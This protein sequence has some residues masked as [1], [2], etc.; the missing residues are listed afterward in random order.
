MTA[1]HLLTTVLHEDAQHGPD[2]DAVLRSVQLGVQRHRRRRRT[3]AI[4]TVAV[5]TAAAVAVPS[6]LP[7]EARTDQRTATAP[8]A[9]P[10]SVSRPVTPPVTVTPSTPSAR[11]AGTVVLVPAEPAPSSFAQALGTVPQGWEPYDDPTTNRTHATLYASPD[12]PVQD[13]RQTILVD[14]T[15]PQWAPG[16]LTG[17]IDG[18]PA[19]VARGEDGSWQALVDIGGGL[20]LT[21]AFPTALD[22]LTADQVTEITAS[23][24]VRDRSRISVG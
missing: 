8:A 23:A 19:L 16:E 20:R 13:F 17:T 4:G 9:V 12:V 15:T 10:S 7:H 6:L 5:A 11:S 24:V 14:V 2:P 22:E 3:V 18:R 21:I 1:P